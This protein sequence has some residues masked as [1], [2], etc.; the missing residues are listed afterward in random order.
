MANQ[1]SA[2]DQLKEIK[3]GTQEILPEKDLL[4][5]LEKS[6]RTKKPLT[7]KAGFDPTAPDIHLGHTVLMQK[8]AQFQQLG[9][10]VVFLIGDF[11][12]LV[13]DPSGKSKTRPQLTRDEVLKNTETYKKQVYK[14]LDPEKTVI[15]FNSEWLEKFSSYDFVRLASH[16]NVARMLEREDFNRRYRE[17]QSIS[18]HEFMYPLLQAYDSVAL[19][20]D[21][22]LGGTDQ[23][24]NLLMGRE[25]MQDYQLEPQ[26]CI[27]MPLLEGLDGVQKM[28]KSLNNYVGV[29]ESPNE[30]FG[31]LLSLPDS[32]MRKYY[33][34]LSSL[35]TQEIDT[36]FK[37]LQAGKHHPK[38]VKVSFAKEIVTRFHNS[39][40]AEEAEHHFEKVFAK[41]E[42]PDD[43]PEFLFTATEGKVWVPKL[44]VDIKFVGSTSEG[45]RMVAQGAVRIN[46][47]VIKDE[48]VQVDPKSILI[49][50]CGKR[51]FAKITLS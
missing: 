21:V 14:I 31:K 26:V 4:Q 22:E 3:R 23:K 41:K 33:D 17:G 6:V 49:L 20:A 12:G 11:T 25:L 27:T 42:V 8:M 13:G 5:K 46:E 28:S 30:I 34:L 9:H 43:L 10:T 47:T 36:L 45:K 37:E 35:G 40:A 32:M 29:N 39:K 51:K 7:V 50:Q 38:T 19:K 15:K 2:Q 1:L 44:L 48:T 18:L 24:F 16:A